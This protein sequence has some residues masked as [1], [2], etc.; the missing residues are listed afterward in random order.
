[1]SNIHVSRLRVG[2]MQ[3]PQNNAAADFIE[4]QAERINELEVRLSGTSGYCTQCEALAAQNQAMREAI[5]GISL[6]E[7][8]SMSSRQEM[9]R[10]ARYAL[11][12]P[13]HSAHV[14]DMVRAKTLEEAAEWFDKG[15]GGTPQQHLRRMAQELRSKK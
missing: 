9:G 13:D 5:H 7:I 10:L 12:L 15:F 3:A 8:N 4:Q 11:A 1:M 6:C 14:L 2:G